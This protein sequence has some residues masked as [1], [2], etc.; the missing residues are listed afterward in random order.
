MSD[1]MKKNKIVLSV[2][3]LSFLILLFV[4]VTQPCLAVPGS[5]TWG[6]P[7]LIKE[8]I[9][10]DDNTE[11]PKG[12]K[13]YVFNTQ[14]SAFALVSK[15]NWETMMSGDLSLIK[16]KIERDLPGSKVIWIQISWTDAQLKE[17]IAQWDYLVKGFRVEAI[18]ENVNAGMTGFEIIAIIIAIAIL[19]VVLS[20]VALGVWITWNLINTIA[21]LPP[22][23]A[24]P[25]EILLLFS[26]GAFLIIIVLA[27]FA[28]SILKALIGK[29]RGHK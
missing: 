18:V 2:S 3:V 1:P 28:P 19:A 24:I 20:C 7:Q 5:K 12:N 9:V 6:T 21:A 27:I 11:I 8:Y 29:R 17:G 15:N 14:Q 25:L 4:L 23:F 10:I 22:A 13:A 16:D 26:I